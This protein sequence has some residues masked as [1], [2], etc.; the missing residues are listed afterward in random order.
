LEIAILDTGIDDTHPDL[1]DLDD[2]PATNDPKVI[3]KKDFTDDNTTED[4]YGHGTYCAGI[5]AGT[6]A[7]P[8]E[9]YPTPTPVPILIKSSVPTST[10]TPPNLLTYSS[11]FTQTDAYAIEV[12][13]SMIGKERAYSSINTTPDAYEPDDN[14]WLANWIPTDGTK[15]LHNFHVPGDLDYVKFN[16]T[17]D[18]RYLIETSDLGNES[19]TYMYLYDTDGLTEITHDDD[20]GEGLA[21]RI[22]W[23]CDESG[24]YYAKVRHY[25]SS[26]C[27][28]YTYY[29]ISVSEYIPP[30]EFNDVYSDYGDDTDGDGLNNSRIIEV[31]VNVTK[32]GRY[33][34][35]GELYGNA[36]G[37]Y[38]IS[39]YNTTYLDTGN[40]S[41]L[42]KFDG[43]RLRQN[44]Y[45]GTYD[46]R[47]LSLYNYTYPYATIEPEI[48]M[49]T[50]EEGVDVLYGE[51]LDYGYF[52]IAYHGSLSRS[53]Q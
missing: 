26:A 38:I 1:D 44:K 27:G 7:A 10:Q 47:Y 3:V 43:I 53:G 39:A 2:N 5:A 40:Y 12:N 24:V 8:S 13:N 15:Q 4:L 36:T 31:G 48:K 23:K 50:T 41:V 30:A 19:D 45:N 52:R 35:R 20:S 22:I 32:A 25:S 21:S 46:L 34:V 51:R 14:Y 11:H 33:R 37:H 16:A 29:N 17:K 18:E 28:P 42:L 9:P 49:S 6:G